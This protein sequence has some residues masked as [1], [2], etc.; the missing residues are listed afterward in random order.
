[1]PQVVFFPHCG[2]AAIRARRRRVTSWSGLSSSLQSC[3]RAGLSPEQRAALDATLDGLEMAL[4]A[5]D[6]A[7]NPAAPEQKREQAQG[8]QCGQARS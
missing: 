7:G 4:A 5:L 2:K 8:G 3:I 1:M 6:R